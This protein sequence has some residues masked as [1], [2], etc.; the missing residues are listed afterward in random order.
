RYWPPLAVSMEAMA[1]PSAVMVAVM[2]MLLTALLLF[3]NANLQHWLIIA[4]CLSINL[5]S[6]RPFG[7]IKKRERK[8]DLMELL[9]LKR[10]RLI[11]VVNKLADDEIEHFN[12]E[13]TRY[14]SI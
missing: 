4:G 2:S 8:I 13:F 3:L 5:L 14:I 1:K 6:I 10:N 11:R 12:K 9:K 7:G